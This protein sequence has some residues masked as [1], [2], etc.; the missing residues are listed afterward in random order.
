MNDIRSIASPWHVPQGPSMDIAHH[1]RVVFER[2]LERL[3]EPSR[4]RRGGRSR[5]RVRCLRWEERLR[6]ALWLVGGHLVGGLVAWLHLDRELDARRTVAA[7]TTDA[8]R[9]RHR[10]LR[11]TVVLLLAGMRLRFPTPYRSV[12]RDGR[13]AGGAGWADAARRAGAVS[14]SS[15]LSVCGSR[16]A[17][18]SSAS[19][20]GRARAARA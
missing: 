1:A 13:L 6:E 17:R 2:R 20:R 9:L 4:E 14:R 10:G 7:R 15:S 5:D 11:E 12:N 18:P 8:R 3:V 19:W 16:P